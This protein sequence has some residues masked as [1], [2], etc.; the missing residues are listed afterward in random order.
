MIKRKY[1]TNHSR[2][3]LIP[4]MS[5]EIE[6]MN[7]INKS[8]WKNNIMTVYVFKV[9]LLKVPLKSIERKCTEKI[10]EVHQRVDLENNT[11]VNVQT[12]I[13]H[14]PGPAPHTRH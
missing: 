12:L 11:R 10:N 14:C 6:L 3:F 8:K 2:P 13:S 9:M 1:S 4:Y 7:R 5:I